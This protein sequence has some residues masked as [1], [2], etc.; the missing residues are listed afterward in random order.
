MKSARWGNPSAHPRTH[1]RGLCFQLNRQATRSTGQT[2]HRLLNG[3]TLTGGGAGS[4]GNSV[5]RGVN[6]SDLR[7][8]PNRSYG[9]RPG[10]ITRCGKRQLNRGL[11]RSPYSRATKNVV[12]CGCPLP[13]R[14]ELLVPVHRC[15]QWH[16]GWIRSV[17]GSDLPGGNEWTQY[18]YKHCQPLAPEYNVSPPARNP[19]GPVD[20]SSAPPASRDLCTRPKRS[21]TPTFRSTP[22]SPKHRSW[23]RSRRTTPC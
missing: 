10:D 22:T 9:R 17:S 5:W 1:R 3:F 2:L 12:K 16:S 23:A 15:R 21:R 4:T 20:A 13:Q 19:R 8:G 18:L 6:G 14:V 7:A 11:S